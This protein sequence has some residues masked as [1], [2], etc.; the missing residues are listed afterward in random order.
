MPA[1]EIPHEQ[2]AAFL[3]KFADCHYGW[4]VKME[5]Q[6]PKAGRLIEAEHGY[7]QQVIADRAGEHDQIAIVVGSPHAHSQTHVIQDAKHIRAADDPDQLEIDAEDGTT[8]VL[9]LQN[10]KSSA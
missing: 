1:Q 9:R 4:D 7:L 8:T 10:P 5:Q 6:R 3:G 2:W